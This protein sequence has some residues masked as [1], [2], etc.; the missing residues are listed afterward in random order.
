MSGIEA[1]M[2]EI[3]GI[4]YKTLKAAWSEVVTEC[5]DGIKSTVE[6]LSNKNITLE[7]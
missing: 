7:R 6:Q 4:S 5:L 2:N 1:V 3:V